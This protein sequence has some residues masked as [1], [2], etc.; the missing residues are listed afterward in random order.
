MWTYVTFVVQIF[1]AIAKSEAEMQN[2]TFVHF[3]YLC[4]K[5]KL[6]AFKTPPSAIPKTLADT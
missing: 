6:C 2:R 5:F 3:M 1:L 4:A